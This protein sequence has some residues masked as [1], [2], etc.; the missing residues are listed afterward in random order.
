MVHYEFNILLELHR[1]P[2]QKACETDWTETTQYICF[3]L[4]ESL[5]YLVY[6]ILLKEKQSATQW[7]NLASTG[8]LGKV[9]N[10]VAS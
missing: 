8:N 1:S 10:P 5:I 9:Y 6:S 2:L 3:M 4:L 7:I